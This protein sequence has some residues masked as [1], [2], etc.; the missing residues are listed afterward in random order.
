MRSALLPLCLAAA[1][2]V[3]AAANAADQPAPAT[4]GGR[5][6]AGGMMS[7]DAMNCMGMSDARIAAVKAELKLTDAQLPLWNA[8]LAAVETN[9]QAMQQRMGMMQGAGAGQGMGP[10]GGMMMMM[11]SGP[12]PKRLAQHETM[13]AAHLDA[14]RQVEAAVTPFYDS[15]TPD[16]KTEADRLLCGQ[17][18]RSSS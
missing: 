12:L 1:L 15:L 13:M 2:G 18:G 3:G 4:Q 6:M 7:M 9:K 8:F 16:Q 5:M 17:M 14:L 10:G 11:S